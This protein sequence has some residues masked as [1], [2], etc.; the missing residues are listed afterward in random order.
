MFNIDILIQN[1][2]LLVRTPI[3]TEWMIIFSLFFNITI[4]SVIILLCVAALI[5]LFRGRNYSILFLSTVISGSII[6]YVLKVIF[7]V[8][9]PI[10]QVIPAFGKSFPS[11]HAM[12]ATIFFGILMYVFDTY[13][14]KWQR[15][16]F[17][18]LCIIAIGTV[19]FS[20]IYLGDHWLS[21]VL[22]GIALGA[23]LSY[24][25]V[26]IFRRYRL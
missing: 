12:M 3:T 11:Y 16:A 4:A 17:N 5:Y 25:C 20:R 19:S 14:S 21:D 15:I 23:L 7:N 8:S 26:I 13:F 9:R 2:L 24:G 1:Y 18:T 6:C 10:D 22:G